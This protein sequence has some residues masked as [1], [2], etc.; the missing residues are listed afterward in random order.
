MI[1]EQLFLPLNVP[2]SD[3]VCLNKMFVPK[4]RPLLVLIVCKSCQK[5]PKLEAHRLQNS[6]FLSGFRARQTKS[7]FLPG[8]L[9]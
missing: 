3:F 1:C 2:V 8:F 6:Q 4:R 5:H 7:Q 9:L